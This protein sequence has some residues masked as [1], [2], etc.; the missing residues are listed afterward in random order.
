V[1]R[2]ADLDLDDNWD[3]G[4]YEL[5][6]NLGPKD[7]ARLELAL[8]SLRGHAGVAM[9]LAPQ[10]FAPA[11]GTPSRLKGHMAVQ[12]SLASLEEY[13]HL[14]GVLRLPSGVAVVCGA[15]AVRLD[16]DDADWLDFYLPLGA[17]A[18]RTRASAV[19]PSATTAVQSRSNG[20]SLSIGGSPMLAFGPIPP[21]LYVAALLFG[22]LVPY[23]VLMVWVYDRTH[24]LLAAILMHLP[25][26]VWGLILVPTITGMAMLS[27][28]VAFGGAL[29]V[30]VAVV[31]LANGG[32]LPRAEDRAVPLAMAA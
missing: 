30:V 16:E 3:G 21:V 32:R 2:P 10:Y 24:S 28:L 14:R 5:A 1:S 27:Y 31:A 15:V 12:L 25:A 11:P 8:A 6:I 17:L 7:D 23:R 18:K 26:D 22:W 20:G 29:W 13:G 19:I 4:F 9:C